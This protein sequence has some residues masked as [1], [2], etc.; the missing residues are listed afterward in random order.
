MNNLKCRVWNEKIKRSYPY[1]SGM[2]YWEK[3]T[4]NQYLKKVFV[5]RKCPLMLFTGSKDIA[6]VD[7]YEE[8]IGI[9][10]QYTCILKYSVL[11]G[12]F[13]WTDIISNQWITG[14]PSDA[15]LIGN[16]YDNPELLMN[17][18]KLINEEL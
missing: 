7:A 6:G 14:R 9:L 10:G 4:Q 1:L 17:A 3:I 16:R 11:E 12:R 5:E 2:M 15:R 8:D 13:W 18:H